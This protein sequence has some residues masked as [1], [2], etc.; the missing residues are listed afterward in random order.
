MQS[1]HRESLYAKY[2]MNNITVTSEYN[3]GM[4]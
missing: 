4:P 2:S 1:I 3:G